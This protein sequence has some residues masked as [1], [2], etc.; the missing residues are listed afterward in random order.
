MQ[1][2]DALAFID[3]CGPA[4]EP[5]LIDARGNLSRLHK[6][7]P[8]QAQINAQ[9]KQAKR[10]E[11]IMMRQMRAQ[12]QAAKAAMR[13]IEAANVQQPDLA[14]PP[15]AQTSTSADVTAAERDLM[16]QQKR[17]VGLTTQTRFAGETGG[18]LGGTKTSLGSSGSGQTLMT[19]G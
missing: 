17:K 8:S 19:Q 3:S 2:D 11:E 5:G 13:S 4:F 6:G 10:Q 12:E 14:P 9:K 16:E 7:G 15:P 18:Y 1:H